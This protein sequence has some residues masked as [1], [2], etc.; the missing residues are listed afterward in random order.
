[1]LLPLQPACLSCS[2]ADHIERGT[3]AIN[4]AGDVPAVS[5]VRLSIPTIPASGVDEDRPQVSRASVDQ[6]TGSAG[7]D[8]PAAQSAARPAEASM[9]TSVVS[10]VSASGSQGSL[11][12]NSPPTPSPACTSAQG[13]EGQASSAQGRM[14]EAAKQGPAQHDGG[15][16][17]PPVSTNNSQAGTR[18]SHCCLGLS[19]ATAA[20]ACRWHGACA[21]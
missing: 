11:A 17:E 7:A 6:S 9:A 5:A 19:T 1:M 2:A 14:E 18:H 21:V 16:L 8:A 15:V 13:S 12:S 3:L 20:R 10:L 4:T